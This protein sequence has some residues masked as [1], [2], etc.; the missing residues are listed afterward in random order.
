MNDESALAS[1]AGECLEA[2]SESQHPYTYTMLEQVVGN[3]DKYVHRGTK[4]DL[5]LWGGVWNYYYVEE[6]LP[7]LKDF[8]R[9][10]WEYSA[11][12]GDP[13]LW[14]W[15]RALLIVNPE[16]SERSFMYELRWDANTKVVHAREEVLKLNWM[17]Y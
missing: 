11:G 7:L 8:L 14:E 6:E 9:R 10:C 5:F 15:E 13:I 1:V 3:L 17:Q 2:A 4:G 16:Q 12:V